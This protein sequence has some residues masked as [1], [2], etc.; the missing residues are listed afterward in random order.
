MQ[1]HK[2]WRVLNRGVNG[3]RT[4]QI[5]ARFDRDVLAAHPRVVVILAGVNDVYQGRTVESVKAQLRAMYDRAR[6]SGILVVA[7][8]I[9]PYTT[10]SP[11][12]N[13]K[14]HEINAW[15]AE[16]P[17]HDA[18]VRF[19]DT[20]KAAALPN[21]QDHLSGSPDGLHPD[22]EGYRKMAEAI[23]AALMTL[24]RSHPLSL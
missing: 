19:V 20:R 1:Q 8:S 2:E 4:D 14:M 6:Q 3:E 22:V 11:A 17:A 21:D 9:I 13:A 15:I 23:G 10:A 16:Q 7:G 24:S 5:A 12:Q 18:N